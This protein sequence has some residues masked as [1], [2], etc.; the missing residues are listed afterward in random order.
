MTETQAKFFAKINT[1]GT[2]ERAALRRE[3]GKT[4]RQADGHAVTTF[5][6]CLPAEV[7]EWDEEKWFAIACLRCLWDPGEENRKPMEQVIGDLI[8]MD[9]ISDSTCHRVE[10]LLDTDWDADG[11]LL[12]KLSRLLKL[13]RQRS[14]RTQIDF[15][16]LLDDLLRWNSETQ[17]VQ[18]KWARAVFYHQSNTDYESKG[19]K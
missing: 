10:I 14:D 1:L 15:S 12:A 9:D 11:Y 8:R 4:L 3:A 6:R 5:Y 19:E 13:I 17:M 2:G 7:R 18:R 16:V